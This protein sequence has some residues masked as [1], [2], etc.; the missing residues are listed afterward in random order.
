MNGA[1]CFFPQES[2]FLEIDGMIDEKDISKKHNYNIEH[3]RVLGQAI[4]A[5]S[6]SFEVYARDDLKFSFT[7][8][9]A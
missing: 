9:M 5:N 3:K 8:G 6:V 1:L 2:S 7:W 4:C